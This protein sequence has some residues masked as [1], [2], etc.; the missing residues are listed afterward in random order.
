MIEF[1]V[2]EYRIRLSRYFS[3]F[4]TW[5]H[6]GSSKGWR[7]LFLQVGWFKGGKVEVKK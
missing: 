1:W 2:K 5:H 7:F 4:E 3:L 6:G